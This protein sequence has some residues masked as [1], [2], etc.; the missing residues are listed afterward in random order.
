MNA[1]MHLKINYSFL[2]GVYVALICP[3]ANA[4]P[5]G[6]EVI[7]GN[8]HISSVG[9]TTTIN[10]LSSVMGI[11]WKSFNLSAHETVNFLQP[12][13]SAVVVNRIFDFN[14]SQIMGRIN[15]NGQVFLI[16]PNGLL[17]GKDAYRDRRG[18]KPKIILMSTPYTDTTS[19]CMPCE[20]PS[21]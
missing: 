11:D 4:G 16:N 17:F 9:T 7:S 13:P 19:V 2:V 15:S 10:Q 8:G 14:G 18:G 3:G 12:S 20:V 21:A 6:G 5:Q 1:E